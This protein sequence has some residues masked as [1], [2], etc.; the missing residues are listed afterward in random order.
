MKFT[1][2]V[3]CV[4]SN[5]PDFD[6]ENEIDLDRVRGHTSKAAAVKDVAQLADGGTNMD[7]VLLKVEWW[8][9]GHLRPP[10]RVRT[11]KEEAD[12][13]VAHFKKHGGKVA[14]KPKSKT[15]KAKARK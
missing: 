12:A 7:V 5:D 11:P 9:A 6:E 15:K 1:Y 13:L 10:R 3:A 2:I 8:G 14:I 4:G